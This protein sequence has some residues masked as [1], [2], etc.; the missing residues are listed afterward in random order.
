M[1]DKYYLAGEASLW[2]QPDGANTEPIY[3][4]CHSLGDIDRPRGDSEPIWCQDETG[5][6]KFKIVG[7]IKGAPGL[8]TSTVTAKLTDDLDQL[9][10]AEF[11]FTLF[12]NV[13]KAGRRDIF[14]N[15]DRIFVLGQ[16][17]ITNEGITGLV[18]SNPDD[19][20]AAEQTF[21]I[22]SESLLRLATYDVLRQSNL[23]ETSNITDLAFVGESRPR[24]DETAPQKRTDIGYASTSAPAGSPATTANV[25]RTINGGATWTAMAADPFAATENVIAVEV[26]YISRNTRRVVVARGTTDAGNPAEIAYT[27]D[28]GATW[29]LVNVGSVNGQFAATQFSLFALNQNNIWFGTNNGYVYKSSDSGGTWTAQQ[30]GSITSGEI[31]CIR[32]VDRNVGWFGGGTNIIARTIDG[33]GSWSAVS[34]P[35]A[36]AAVVVNVVEP[37]DRNRAWVGYADGEVYYTNDAG[38][39]WTQRTSFTGSGI[40]SIRDI[41]FWDENLGVMARNTAAPVGKLMWTPN[42]GYSWLD[43]VEPTNAGINAIE[44]VSEWDFFVAGTAQGGLGFIAKATA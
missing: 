42:G 8:I 30:S 40:G 2:A 13:S 26:F 38:V 12:A 10:K 35:S 17:T 34:G 11:P 20:A 44:L 16:T 39:T 32:F 21:D 6:N 25:L 33:G 4:G 5:T 37:I 14:S 27:D 31:R 24:T 9:E 7:T 23:S 28:E 3:L 19:N 43:L 41:R 15:F 1:A 36:Q 22:S 18:V 29:T